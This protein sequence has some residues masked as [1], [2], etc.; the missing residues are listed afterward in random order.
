MYM[1]PSGHTF[2]ELFDAM[3]ECFFKKNGYYPT[4]EE[5]IRLT[6]EARKATRPKEYTDRNSGTKK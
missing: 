5:A 1:K 2:S 6:D 4:E 3:S